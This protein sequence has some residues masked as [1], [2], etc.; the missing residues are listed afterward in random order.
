M[1]L[2]SKKYLLGHISLFFLLKRNSI[3][4]KGLK[5]NSARDVQGGHLTNRKKIW[6]II[7]IGGFFFFFSF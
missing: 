6:L 3:F 4:Q 7:F 5:H 1:S 2:R